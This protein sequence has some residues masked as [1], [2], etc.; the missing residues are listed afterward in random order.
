MVLGTRLEL[1]QV[2]VSLIP[3][4]VVPGWSRGGPGQVCHPVCYILESI[5]LY[6]ASCFATLF[7]TFYNPSCS[8]DQCQSQKMHLRMERFQP[9]VIDQFCA[10]RNRLFEAFVTYGNVPT[11]SNTH[12]RFK[13]VPIGFYPLGKHSAFLS[14][15][16]RN[17]GK[18]KSEL[19]MHIK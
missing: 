6:Q 5:F 7:G 19:A 1:F 14:K 12:S 9:E 3:G 13:N 11:W 10:L 18:C 2:R 15:R 8:P 16:H 17:V 4:E